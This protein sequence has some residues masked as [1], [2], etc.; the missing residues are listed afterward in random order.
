MGAAQWAILVVVGLVA[1][2]GAAYLLSGG[3][4]FDGCEIHLESEATHDVVY[5]VDYRGHADKASGVLRAG[6]TA[7][8]KL[9]TFSPRGGPQGAL[10]VE[11]L[12]NVSFRLDP[13]CSDWSFLVNDT[14]ITAASRA[15]A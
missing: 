13:Y 6:A 14:V 5:H 11:G 3:H 9:C 4:L 8:V 15:C 10:R 7:S 1:A 2:F 12:G